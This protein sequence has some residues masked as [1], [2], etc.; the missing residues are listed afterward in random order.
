DERKHQ[1]LLEAI[2]SLGVFCRRR[3]RVGERSEAAAQMSEFSVT[4]AG[5]AGDQID[6]SELIGTVEQTP[7]VAAHTAKQLKN[8]QRMKKTVESPLS[9]QQSQKVQRAA[10]F[11]KAATEVSRWSAFITQ[12]RRAEQLVFPLNQ[13]PSGPKPVERVAMGWTA[14]TPLEE[15]IFSLLANKQP[16]DDPAL[17]PAD[18][19]SVRAMSLEEA[20]A[21]RAELQKNRALQSYYEARAR[22]EKRIKSKKFHKV[23]NKGKKKEF[24]RRFEDLAKADPGALEELQKVEVAR[25]QERMSLKHQNS[26]RWARTKAI[27]AKY[28]QDARKAMQEQLEVHKLTQKVAQKMLPQ[29]VNDVE[30]GGDPSNPWMRGTLSEEPTEGSGVEPSRREEGMRLEKTS[31]HNPPN[32]S[33]TNHLFPGLIQ[34][35]LK[36]STADLLLREFESRRKER[37]EEEFHRGPDE[38]QLEDAQQDDD[39]L[40]PGAPPPTLAP[41]PAES[42]PP[43]APLTKKKRKRRGIELTEV[44]T[45]GSVE[46]RVPLPLSLEEDEDQEEV[47][48]QRGLIREAFAGDDV[49]AD[50]LKDKRAHEDAA[51]PKTVDLT[52]PGWGEWAGVGLPPS[53][54]KRRRFRVRAPAPSSRKDAKLP[55]VIISEQRNGAAGL[56]QVSAL[57]FPFETQEQFE[58]TVRVP[59]GRTW[60]TERTVSKATAPR[61]LTQLGAIIQ[62]M[63]RQEL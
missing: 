44:L 49:V 53:R 37:Q 60:N 11:Q 14:R 29:F 24:L 26:G 63:A 43:E 10:A 40:H 59:V 50:F 23:Q 47:Q 18:E 13:E 8:L 9:K 46:V 61:V 25:M 17:T 42:P 4:P 1:K 36:G 34:K 58:S 54:A 22:R 30:R 19:A 3:K 20:R 48:D 15:E 55:A 39:V 38:A 7:G 27:M 35:H 33:S 51:A 56:H 32:L 6:L 2:S 16:I 52:L 62:P 5:E 28:D 57:P 21:R 45:K 41:P 31:K 12:N